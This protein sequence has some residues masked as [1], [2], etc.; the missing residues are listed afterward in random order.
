MKEFGLAVHLKII[1]FVLWCV[2]VSG[3]K[4]SK[5]KAK[6]LEPVLKWLGHEYHSEENFSGIPAERQTAFQKLRAPHSFAEMSSRLGAFQY[7]QTYIPNLKKLGSALFSLAKS[8]KF[9]WGR[10]ESEQFE[11]I[12]EVIAATL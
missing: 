12:K 10:L 9:Y 8:E 7:F 4:F 5:K 2:T 6:I 1:D 11:N 3:V